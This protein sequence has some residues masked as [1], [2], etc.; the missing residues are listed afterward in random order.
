MIAQYS[1]LFDFL[2]GDTENND[3]K[4]IPL[5][6]NM[7]KLYPEAMGKQ[8]DYNLFSLCLTK[9][10]DICPLPNKDRF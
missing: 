4:Y 7:K 10:F 1:N 5:L 6:K 8:L 3:I 2:A 9:K